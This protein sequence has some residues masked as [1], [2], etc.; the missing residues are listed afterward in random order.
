[1]GH[2]DENCA[3]AVLDAF[4][5]VNTNEQLELQ[6]LFLSENVDLNGKNHS[7]HMLHLLVDNAIRIVNEQTW[8]DPEHKR[9]IIKRIEDVE[10]KIAYSD[11]IYDP[12]SKIVE[13]SLGQYKLTKSYLK[14]YFTLKKKEFEKE[15]DLLD[16]QQLERIRS[17]N[18]V[19][20]IYL[21]NLIYLKD[22][23]TLLMPAGV[24]V[25]P[26]FDINNQLY[27]NYATIGAYISHE[28]W[29]LIEVAL[30]DLLAYK[31]NAESCLLTNYVAYA[32]EKFKLDVS[33]DKAYNSV[34]EQIADIF[35]V[36][37]AFDTYMRV[38]DQSPWTSEKFKRLPGLNLT[39]EQLFFVRYAQGYCKSSTVAKNSFEVTHSE[40][41][42]RVY[43]T[44]F[45]PKFNQVFGCNSTN[46]QM[47]QGKQCPIFNY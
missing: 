1:L 4:S 9:D 45:V 30:D 18:Y 42:Y 40:D 11:Y 25:E 35:G 8:I 38:H 17:N 2:R 24:L 27:L 7:L 23:N 3:Y 6:R 47:F 41:S 10:M 20:G 22:F 33:I 34:S 32:K 28:L 37:N 19:F 39:P 43:Q 46:L 36:Y 5:I 21:T 16:V 31:L 14:N 13:S 12:N 44:S 15:Y 29:H 26:I